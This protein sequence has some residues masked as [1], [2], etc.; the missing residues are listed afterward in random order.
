MDVQK[1]YTLVYVEDDLQIAKNFCIFFEKFFEKVVLAT[2]VQEGYEA[3]ISHQ[4]QI[5]VVDITL[6]DG[7]GLSLIEKIRQDDMMTKIIVLTAHSDVEK[8]LHATTLH[9]SKYIVKP[10]TRKD[11]KEALMLAIEE[12]EAYEVVAKKT[13]TIS[14]TLKWDL[15]KQEFVGEYI[16]LTKSEKKLLAYMFENSGKTLSYEE[17]E[18]HL[19]P[20]MYE[21]KTNA[22][23]TIIKNLRKKVAYDIIKNIY[24]EGYQ[25]N[26]DK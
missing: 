9:L 7:S 13:F 25:L 1:N 20:D 11:I 18:Y 24:G 23:K 19:W 21:D 10:V 12:Y 2:S 16:N 26:C 22:I 3:Y 5:M 8:L 6:P 15:Q 4:P 14:D 17:L